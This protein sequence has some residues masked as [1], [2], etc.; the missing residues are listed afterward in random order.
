MK[1]LCLVLA[2]S[3]VQ[4]LKLLKSSDKPSAELVDKT[5]SYLLGT[6]TD[7]PSDELI[8]ARNLFQKENK[9]ACNY[10]GQWLYMRGDS[11][12]RQVVG[13]MVTNIGVHLNEAQMKNFFRQNCSRPPHSPDYKSF[14]TTHPGYG[15]SP[16]Y[17]NERRCDWHFQNTRVTYDWQHFVFEER[18]Q[19]LFN[20]DAMVKDME[21]D[22][23]NGLPD[24]V[25]IGLPVHVCGHTSPN[26]GSEKDS[27]YDAGA[28]KMYKDDIH[29]LH[30][31]I[32]SV[33]DKQIIYVEAAGVTTKENRKLYMDC[34]A[35]MNK[36]LHEVVK[37]D[38]KTVVIPRLQIETDWGNNT[39]TTKKFTRRHL[40]WSKSSPR[41]A[42]PWKHRRCISTQESKLS[43]LL[44]YLVHPV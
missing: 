20:K 14:Q 44:L 10:K 27:V 19:F 5:A 37:G 8:T 41:H 17:V 18:E 32:R 12:M 40:V 28:Q 26:V 36:E 30:T 34:I 2:V 4:A 23:K 21:H 7:I 38:A 11:S 6:P 42:R 9:P 22:F 13:M 24:K 31:A 33:F 16:C 39:L 29:K 3:N 25:V 15:R 35:N 43:P 1:F